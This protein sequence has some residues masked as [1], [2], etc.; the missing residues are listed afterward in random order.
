MSIAACE[1][2]AVSNARYGL[3]SNAEWLT[4]RET[5]K[6]LGI[7][8]VTVYRLLAT[9]GGRVRTRQAKGG[10]LY[11]AGGVE[12]ILRPALAESR[13]QGAKRQRRR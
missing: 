9:H 11:S 2:K 8:P 1:A 5:A 12:S 13:S 7:R 3:R 6:R 10:R 4:L